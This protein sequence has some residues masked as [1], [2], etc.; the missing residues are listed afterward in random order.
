[1]LP[2]SNTNNWLD[3]ARRRP[4]LPYSRTGKG[5]LVEDMVTPEQLAEINEN[6][7]GTRDDL[8][9]VSNGLIRTRSAAEAS[10][11]RRA[12]RNRLNRAS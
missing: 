8:K 9:E 4:S 11:Q 1:M 5:E 3:R 10:G 2:E 7:R 12:I 6:L